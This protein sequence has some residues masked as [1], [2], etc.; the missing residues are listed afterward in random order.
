MKTIIYFQS[1]E[2]IVWFQYTLSHTVLAM[3]MMG[4][5]QIIVFCLKAFIMIMIC[6]LYVG[7]AS[8][9]YFNQSVR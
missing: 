1:Y 4:A 2:K 7:F 9:V 6:F 3:V 8:K 5:F